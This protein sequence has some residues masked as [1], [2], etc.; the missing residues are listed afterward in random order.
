MQLE[1]ETYIHLALGI[2]RGN[3]KK[4]M[5]WAYIFRTP[6]LLDY[7]PVARG[8]SHQKRFCLPIY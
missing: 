7:H 1:T 8:P 2:Y 6:F 3:T 5:F 4:Y